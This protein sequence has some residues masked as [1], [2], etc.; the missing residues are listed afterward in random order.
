MACCSTCCRV[1]GVPFVKNA[2]GMPTPTWL[3]CLSSG[4][5][6]DAHHRRFRNFTGSHLGRGSR[7]ITAG[8]DSHRPR[9]TLPSYAARAGRGRVGRVAVGLPLGVADLCWVRVLPSALPR[10][11]VFPGAGCGFRRVR[12]LGCGF[13]RARLSRMRFSSRPRTLFVIFV[14]RRDIRLSR[15]IAAGARGLWAETRMYAD[16]VDN[17]DAGERMWLACHACAL[18]PL[19]FSPAW[20]LPP[21]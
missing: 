6:R 12:C 5:A 14:L 11:W 17:Y 2:P 18:A 21:C 15:D 16:A 19:L 13:C 7:T 1:I 8:S 10:V 20:P 4:L 3:C 9:S